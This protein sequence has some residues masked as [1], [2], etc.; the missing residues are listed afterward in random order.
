M[1]IPLGAEMQ[2]SDFKGWR[3]EGLRYTGDKEGGEANAAGEGQIL[4]G[5]AE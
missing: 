2:V 1:G 4:Q 5:G 3:Q